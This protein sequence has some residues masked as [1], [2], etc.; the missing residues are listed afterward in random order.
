M[1]WIMSILNK[2]DKQK[3]VLPE[4]ALIEQLGLRVLALEE[5]FENHAHINQTSIGDPSPYPILVIK[6]K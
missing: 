4:A 3:K 2:K 5:R 1:G 6:V